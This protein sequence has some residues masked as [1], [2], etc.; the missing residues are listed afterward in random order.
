MASPAALAMIPAAIGAVGS[1]VGGGMANSANRRAAREQM[2]FQERMSNTAHQREVKDLR[3]AGLNPILSANSGASSPAGAMAQQHDIVTLGINTALAAAQVAQ[4]LKSAK[5]QEMNTLADTYNKWKQGKLIQ[6]QTDAIQPAAVGGAALGQ[7]AEKGVQA[8]SSNYDIAVDK[9]SQGIEYMLDTAIPTI[10]GLP[11]AGFS[12]AKNAYEDS[13]KWM[14]QKQNEL[15]EWWQNLKE[16]E[17]A[18]LAER[19]KKSEH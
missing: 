11:S 15:I 17:K 19:R 1:I 13:E 5:A 9:T 18:N 10:K 14:K 12:S 4:S 7:A 16:E 8:I 6:A 2:A 3:A